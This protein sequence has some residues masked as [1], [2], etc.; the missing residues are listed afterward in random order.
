MSRKLVVGVPDLTE[1]DKKQI[2]EA[3]DRNGF[4]VEFCTMQEEALPAD[5]EIVFSGSPAFAKNAEKLRWQCSVSAGVNQFKGLPVFENGTA[6]LSNS[7]GAYGVT[8]AEHLVMMTLEM[9]RR[10]VEFA[11]AAA[12]KEWH[13]PLPVK[14]VYGSRV[15]FAGTGDIGFETAKRIRAFEPAA[16]YG[17]NRKGRNPENLFD[18]IYT[19]EQIEEVLPQT[20]ILIISMPGTEETFHMLDEKRLALLPDGAL[21]VNVGRG[22]IIDEA[23]LLPE[24]TAGR[25]AAAL[26]VF[27]TEPL[28]ADNPLWDC[29]NLLILPHVAGNMTLP[30]TREKIVAQFLEDFDNYCAGRPLLRQVDLKAGY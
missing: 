6:L 14:S 18:R 20:D 19:Q 16:L 25:L 27:E 8:I 4:E 28:P 22:F 3:A 9:L 10:Q 1:G 13:K 7:S 12:R 11:A 21:I 24:L 2:I 30:H 5:G 29:P 17:V 26:D 23:A 15:T